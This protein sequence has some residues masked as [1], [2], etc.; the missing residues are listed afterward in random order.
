MKK[1]GNLKIITIVALIVA[2]IGLGVGFAA[3]SRTLTIQSRAT[4]SPS[5]DTF[6]VG[7][8]SSATSLEAGPAVTDG[9]YASGGTFQAGSTTLSDLTASFTAP[10]Q[11]ATWKVYAFNSG[12]YEAFLNEVYVGSI[13]C[14]PKEGTDA[15]MVASAC[16]SLDVSVK[17][18][19]NTFETSNNSISAHRLAK[20]LGEEVLVSLSYESGGARADGDFDVALG[21]IYLFYGSVD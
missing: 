8:S 1:D 21:N 10:G 3:F 5:S 6:K 19:A 11:T 12:E 4:V 14:T 20:G 7:F 16:S 2:V 17:V 18:G 9:T 15:A 13:T